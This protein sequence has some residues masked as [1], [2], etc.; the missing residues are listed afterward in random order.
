[1]EDSL[2]LNKSQSFPQNNKSSFNPKGN[3]ELK[4]VSFKQKK[5]K[6]EE[7]DENDLTN[8]ILSNLCYENFESE[9]DKYYA[10]YHK[11]PNEIY[12]ENVP[13]LA[14]NRFRFLISNNSSFLDS[15]TK[16]ENGNFKNIQWEDIKLIYYYYV[17][18]YQCPICLEKKLCCPIIINCGHIFC[19]PCFLNFYNYYTIE[20]INKKVPNCPLCSEKIDLEK[21]EIKF[22]EMIK[23]HNY[24]NHMQIKFNLIMREK[25]SPTLFNLFYDPNLKKWKKSLK[26][27]MRSIPLEISKE[28]I[29]SRIFTPTKN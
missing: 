2:S 7:S 10:H 4:T 16:Y 23:C 14:Q 29:F 21:K 3:T 17:E 15:Y 5:R 27:Q 9:N 11:K 26:N 18:D 28:F 22:C 24:T 12:I 19:Y 13:L 8:K 1:M 25:T 20:S 6:I